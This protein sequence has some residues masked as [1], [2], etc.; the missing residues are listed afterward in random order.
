MVELWQT[1]IGA[2]GPISIAVEPAREHDMQKTTLVSANVD[3][4]GHRHTALVWH[5]EPDVGALPAQTLAAM[6]AKAATELLKRAP[7]IVTW[8]CEKC[9]QGYHLSRRGRMTACEAEKLP[10]DRT[11]KHYCGPLGDTDG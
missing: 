9:G 10:E 7:E 8:H 11:I 4:L 6:I 5:P 1:W 3:H 2:I